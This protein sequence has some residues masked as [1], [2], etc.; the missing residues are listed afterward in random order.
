MSHDTAPASTEDLKDPAFYKCWREE[1]VRFN[2]LD[3]HWHMTST[4]HMIMFESARILFIRRASE[5][6]PDNPRG[7]MLMNATIDYHAQVHF[8][9]AL[10]VGIRLERIGRS[11]VTCVQGLFNGEE[12]VAT[13]RS[14]VILADPG[15]TTSI[16]VPDDVRANL[17]RLSATGDWKGL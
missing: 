6:T 15:L 13:M 8:P 5:A 11:S 12:C 9:A 16:P 4:S 1:I 17:E 2:D 14:T 3:P 10:R 7:W